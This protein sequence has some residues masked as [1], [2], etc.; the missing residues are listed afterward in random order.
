MPCLHKCFLRESEI[1]SV[2]SDSATPWITKSMKFSRPEYWSGQP[3]LSP[4]NLPNLETEPR[5][6]TLQ[7]DSLRVDPPGKPKNTGVGSLALLQGIFLTQES[8]RGLLHCRQ[9][10]YQLSYQRNPLLS[11]CPTF[12]LFLLQRCTERHNT[13]EIQVHEEHPQRVGKS[14]SENGGGSYFS[15]VLF[16][17]FIL[18]KL[19]W[20]I[21]AF[22]CCVGFR[23]VTSY[24][25]IPYLQSP[26]SHP[27]PS[28]AERVYSMP[29]VQEE[30]GAISDV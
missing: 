13:G 25:R 5:S 18:W 1:S 20:S 3:F 27:M 14:A 22:Q 23:C 8:N 6:P 7:A 11:E 2:V 30:C 12:L 10:L 4:G 16:L 19:Y 26:V 17:N 28:S 24:T 21:I 29:S 9:I 15:T